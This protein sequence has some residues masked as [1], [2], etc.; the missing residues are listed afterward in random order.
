[1]SIIDRDEDRTLAEFIRERWQLAEDTEHRSHRQKWEH[2][3]HLYH[4]ASRWHAALNGASARDADEVHAAGQETFGPE[5]FIP[6][7]FTV[8]E[9]I[10]PRMV[11]NRPKI[12]VLPRDEVA[13]PNVDNMRRTID[14]QQDQIDYEITLQS[15]I[16]SALEYGLGSEKTA[17]RLTPHQGDSF[18]LAPPSGT[19]KGTAWVPEKIENPGPAFDDNDV[20]DVDIWNLRWDPLGDSMKTIR[21]LIHTTWRDTN[22]VLGMVKSGSWPLQPNLEAADIDGKGMSENF[23]SAWSGRMK[24]RGYE[25]FAPAG[26]DI[27]EV[28][29]YHDGTEVC[30]VLNRDLIV[31]RQGNGAWHGEIPFDIFRPTE[32]L[33]R[34]AG[35]GEIEPIESLQQEMNT[36]RSQRR[37]NA[38]LKL[39]QVFAYDSGVVDP[40]NIVFA[41]GMLVGVPGNPQDLIQPLQVGDIPYSGFREEERLE[42][43]I[44]RTTG[45]S[46]TVQGVGAAG[47]TATGVQLVQAAANVRIQSKTHRAEIELMKGVG[48]KMLRNNQQHIRG[49]R[50]MLEP[51][52][53]APHAPE[54]RYQWFKTGPAELAGEMYCAIDGGATQPRSEAQDRQDAQFLTPLVQQ[55]MIDPQ[56]GTVLILRKLGIPDPQHYLPPD[57]TVPPETLDILMAELQQLLPGQPPEMIR[58]LIGDALQQATALRE[59][60]NAGRVPGGPPGGAANPQGAQQQL[61]QGG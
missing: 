7:S 17:W 26:K 8:V 29:E 57:Q 60:Q 24:A 16:K 56:K 51:V 39:A 36:L 11:S 40:G 32:E 58:A 10:L 55:G 34:F 28:W 59:Q 15:S 23:T 35:I 13:V 47:Q 41:P 19:Q 1:M 21:Y 4:S 46:D 25:N 20:E 31:K 18:Q 9:T 5:L 30:T 27:H 52:A 2:L 37:F 14:A 38:M 61:P 49:D 45:I 50:V 6:Y 12:L 48:R 22:Y 54:R 42:S 53:P 3:D 43:N 33:H 44:D